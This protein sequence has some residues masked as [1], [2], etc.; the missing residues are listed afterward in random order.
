MSLDCAGT[1]LIFLDV[2]TTG[3]AATDR[4]CSV[5][6][7]A[8]ENKKV[9]LCDEL[10]HPQQKIRPDSM[11]IHHITNEVIRDKPSFA[12]SPASTWL[13]ERNESMH[14]LVLHNSTFEL[15]MLQKEGFLW[16]GEVIDTLK[17]VRHLIPECEQFSL[18]FLRYELQLYKHEAALVESLGIAAVRPHHALSDAL[19]VKMLY[20]Y[21]RD[22]AD[23]AALRTLSTTPVLIQKFYF[24]KYKGRYI[25]EIA[26][27]DR[28]YLEW[29]LQQ[30]D[31]HNDD[32]HYSIGYYLSLL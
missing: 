32:L 17:C 11:M 27:Q 26:M 20:D 19:H 5:G 23:D 25:E 15:Q 8:M 6:A 13:N 12:N 4:I 9:S 30:C 14:I 10:I 24:G 16:Q 21:L 22:L 3:L 18:Q 29:L 7:I 28:Q 2:E 31:E 1:M